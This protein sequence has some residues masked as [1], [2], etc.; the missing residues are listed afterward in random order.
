MVRNNGELVQKGEAKDERRE[1]SDA[2]KD[3]EE[4]QRGREKFQRDGEASLIGLLCSQPAH[5]RNVLGRCA[6][7]ET[8]SGDRDTQLAYE[9]TLVARSSPWPFT[10]KLTHPGRWNRTNRTSVAL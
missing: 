5:D 7:W 6:Q 1:T 10:G 8:D 4:F 9:S 2:L 3:G